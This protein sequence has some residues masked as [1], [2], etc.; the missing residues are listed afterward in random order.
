MFECISFSDTYGDLFHAL[1]ELMEAKGL[2]W[3]EEMVM[4]SDWEQ[5]RVTIGMEI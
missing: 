4:I 2:V 3:K 1:S 5:V